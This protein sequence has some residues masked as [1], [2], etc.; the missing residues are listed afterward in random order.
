MWRG[1]PLVEKLELSRITVAVATYNRNADL[2]VL[3]GSLDD[4]RAKFG[5]GVL[6]VD[7]SPDGIAK[8]IVDEIAPTAVYHHEPKPGIVSARNAALELTQEQQAVIFVDDD[9]Y[10]DA[11]WFETLIACAEAYSAEVVFGPVVP[12]YSPS[13]AHWIKAGGHFERH[14]QITGTQVRSGATNNALIR[15]EAFSRLQLPRFDAS[16]SISG[17]SDAE[18]FQRMSASGAP[19]VWCDEAIVFER[20]PENRA[21]FAWIWNRQVRVGSV[22][23]RIQLQTN[24]KL[25]VIGRAVSRISLGVVRSLWAMLRRRPL[26]A[27]DL[28]PLAR[29]IG[30][31]GAVVGHRSQEYARP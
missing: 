19:M 14:R 30:L 21:N 17:G 9:E 8:N 3:L 15:A 13:C 20:V 31:F 27:N 11:N 5:F 26:S 4:Q 18:L 29:G 22:T 2:T 1:R 16:Y 12:I 23:G 10:V 6:V 24:S 25:R 7:N 28:G